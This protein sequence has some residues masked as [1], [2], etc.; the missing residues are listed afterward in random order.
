MSVRNLLIRACMPEPHHPRPL[1]A[2]VLICTYNRANLLG[3]TLDTIAKSRTTL[4]WEVVVVD[5]NSTDH[6]RSVVAS[7]QANYPVSLRCLSEPRQGNSFGLNTAPQIRPSL[8]HPGRWRRLRG[9][10]SAVTSPRAA[11]CVA[12]SS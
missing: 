1:D 2:T 6:T 5:N 3:E 12:A 8:I 4:A 9:C 10:L 11:G 7:R